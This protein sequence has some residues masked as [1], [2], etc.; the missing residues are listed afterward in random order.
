M[1]C[2]VTNLAVMF[3]WSVAEMSNS[4]IYHYC[5]LSITLIFDG[6]YYFLLNYFS[7]FFYDIVNSCLAKKSNATTPLFSL[8]LSFF[9]HSLT[10]FSHHIVTWL[11]K[12]ESYLLR[13]NT[14]SIKFPWCFAESSKSLSDSPLYVN[15]WPAI[16]FICTRSTSRQWCLEASCWQLYV[17]NSHSG[18]Y[19][20]T[21]YHFSLSE[22]SSK[23][24]TFC[25]WTVQGR[26]IYIYG[27]SYTSWAVCRNTC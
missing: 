11:P 6:L 25:Q 24:P 18:F 9:T 21:V 26:V 19:S 20:V 2:Q 7:Q 3:S 14:I 15:R 5:I 1:Q 17:E 4:S 22:S 12:T 23:A 13:S 16:T 27:R 10:P 8:L